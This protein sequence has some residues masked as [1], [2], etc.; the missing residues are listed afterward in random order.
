MFN[1]VIFT[2]HT[3]LTFFWRWDFQGKNVLMQPIDSYMDSSAVKSV[4]QAEYALLC[5]CNILKH[6]FDKHAHESDVNTLSGGHKFLLYF[7]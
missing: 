2:C 5:I 6:E 3:S 7:N 1:L 4:L